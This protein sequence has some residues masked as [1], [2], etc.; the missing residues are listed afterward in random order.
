[1]YISILIIILFSFTFTGCETA[2]RGAQEVGKPVGAV[3]KTVGG[4]TEGAT[5]AYVGEDEDNPFGR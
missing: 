2:H 4:V 3:M 1:M 5:D